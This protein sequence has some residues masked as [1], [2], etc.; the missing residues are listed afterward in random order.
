MNTKDTIERIFDDYLNKTNSRF[1]KIKFHSNNRFSVQKLK[2]SVVT[3]K[4]IILLKE[5]LIGALK[6]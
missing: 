5:R 3:R 2:R 4:S 6:L 1:I